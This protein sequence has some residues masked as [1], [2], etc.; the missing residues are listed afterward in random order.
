MI[1]ITT[2]QRSGALVEE[3]QLASVVGYLIHTGTSFICAPG[4]EEDWLVTVDLENGD[5][6]VSIAR[7]TRLGSSRVTE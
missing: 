4:A 1:R 3:H 7:D 5:E 6:L 2:H